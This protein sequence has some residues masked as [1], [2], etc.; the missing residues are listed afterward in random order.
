M[1]AVPNFMTNWA[2]A[3]GAAGTAQTASAAA[4]ATAA[5]PERFGW[6]WLC[7]VDKSLIVPTPLTLAHASFAGFGCAFG[8]PTIKGR[9]PLPSGD[10]PRTRARRRARDRILFRDREISLQCRK[11]I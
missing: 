3:A 1:V 4:K 5:A 6:R 11:A 2:A 10:L 9:E 7:Q 8:A